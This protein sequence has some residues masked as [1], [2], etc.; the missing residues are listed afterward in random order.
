[1]PRTEY[2]AD[3]WPDPRP[4]QVE[5]CL[6]G[7][8]HM[9]NPGLD[10]VNVDADDVLA[11]DRQA[12]LRRLVDG[13]ADWSPDRVAVERPHD[14]QAAVAELYRAYRDGEYAYD[15]EHEY[16]PPHHMRDDPTGEC[17]SEVVQVG[18]RLADRLDHETVAAVDEHPDPPEDDPFADRGTDPA[19]KTDVDLPDPDAH[20]DE[21]TRHLAEST[22][23]E[24]LRW[25]NR[26]ERLRFNHDRMFDLGVRT[27]D[28]E[29][30]S[31][32]ALA[33]WYERNTRMV[34]HVWRAL[35]DGD[36]RVLCLVGSGH[37][38]VLRHLFDEAPMFCPR[39]ASVALPEPA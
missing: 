26:P 37:V 25:L 16:D 33:F 9:D 2:D 22:V 36:D 5:V 34:H 19:P 10:E 18:F 1:M 29:F 21:V 30:G 14:Q 4:E 23:A 7:T 39:P 6:L 24:H 28:H 32:T 15:E 11:P 12:D 35:E 20:V 17:R 8:Y 13:L 38:R 31:P 27:A 3:G